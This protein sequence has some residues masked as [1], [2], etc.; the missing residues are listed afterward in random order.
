MDP[1]RIRS[2]APEFNPSECFQDVG[3]AVMRDGFNLDA[4]YLAFKCGPPVAQIG[5]NHFDH[6]SFMLSYAGSWLAW[7]P[8]YRDYFHP[9]RRKYSVGS[10]GH[11]TVILDLDDEYLA[12]TTVTLAGHDQLRLNQGR[13]EEFFTSDS[14]DYLL[15]NAAAAYNP[16]DRTVLDRFDRQVVFAKPNVFFV[17]DTLAAPEAH[18]FSALMHASAQDTLLLEGDAAKIVSGESLLQIHPFSPQGLALSTAVYP[19]AEARGP[20]LAA[21]TPS[22]T[23]ATILTVLVPRP[24]L[25]LIVNPGFEMGMAGWTPRTAEGQ[26][27]NHVIDTEVAH[28]GNASARIDSNGYYYSRPFSLPPGTQYTIRWW[29]RCSGTGAHAYVY[30]SADGVST[31]RVELPGPTTGEW[32]QFETTG[33]VPVGTTQTRLALQMFGEGQCWYDDVEIIREVESG[34]AEPAQVTAL[35][36]GATGAVVE[37]DGVTH[38]MLCATAGPVTAEVAGHTLATDAVIAVVSFT[39]DGPRAFM[40]RG[41]TLTLDGE[42][43]QPTP[44]DWRE[45]PRG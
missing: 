43:L 18:T 28:S 38:V 33:T 29:G 41:T 39:A 8:G 23:S 45:G 27:P 37:V 20:Y 9:Q 25:E 36:G 30:H 32:E 7:D 26:L 11:N 42:P 16:D 35:D 40:L 1:E 19:E 34:P 3:Y 21:T 6:N 14:F 24:H 15:G 31:G 2:E 13:V 12:D 44:G 10:L 22:V 17:R 4:A 5:H